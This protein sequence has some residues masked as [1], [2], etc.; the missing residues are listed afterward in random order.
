MNPISHATHIIISLIW[1]SGLIILNAIEFYFISI[2]RISGS[3]VGVLGVQ[4]ISIAL[5]NSYYLSKIDVQIS[6]TGVSLSQDTIQTKTEV[7]P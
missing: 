4:N 5:A 3:V 1:A 2:G 6:P 7:K